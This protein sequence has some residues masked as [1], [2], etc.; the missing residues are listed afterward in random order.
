MHAFLSQ[1]LVVVLER[2]FTCIRAQRGSASKSSWHALSSSLPFG[3]GYF[4]KI[5]RH[6][7][8]QVCHSKAGRGGSKRNDRRNEFV[9]RSTSRGEAQGTYRPRDLRNS[10]ITLLVQ[11]Y[12]SPWRT[13]TRS[14]PPPVAIS[15]MSR[16][17]VSQKCAP[18]NVAGFVLAN[19][20]RALFA[21]RTLYHPLASR[22]SS[23]HAPPGITLRSAKA[24]THV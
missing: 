13:L 19:I 2:C 4:S 18:S 1:D 11:R 10:L 15:N 7:H 21:R 20:S 14:A 23:R 8:T 5:C 6:T 17:L 22:T 9:W 12:A 16:T 24:R 3:P